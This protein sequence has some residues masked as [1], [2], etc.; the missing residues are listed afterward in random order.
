MFA[1]STSIPWKAEAD[2]DS[3][4]AFD[5]VPALSL[6][7]IIDNESTLDVSEDFLHMHNTG[8]ANNLK[9]KTEW[10]TINKIKNWHL[11]LLNESCK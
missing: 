6:R 10:F 4:S 3:F 8:I 1:G 2:K 9:C 7:K 5:S 11:E